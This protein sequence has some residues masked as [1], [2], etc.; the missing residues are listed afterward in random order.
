MIIYPKHI[1]T[2]R[3]RAELSD[4]RVAGLYQVVAFASRAF[5]SKNGRK[6]RDK[7]IGTEHWGSSS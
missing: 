6:G 3:I 2:I 5:Q 4:G 7:V 1:S